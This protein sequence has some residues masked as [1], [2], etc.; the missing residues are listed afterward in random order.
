MS[1]YFLHSL[2]DHC[3]RLQFWTMATVALDSVFDTVTSVNRDQMFG[4]SRWK[5]WKKTEL[6]DFI[7]RKD[8]TGKKWKVAKLQCDQM[9]KLFF[10]YLVIWKIENLP[11][12]INISHGRFLM[13]PNYKLTIKCC[14]SLLQFYQIGEISPNL[15]T[16]SQ[17]SSMTSEV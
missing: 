4:C 3:Q 10:Q 9:D 6:T 12:A 13:F 2:W 8:K 5:C 17:P 7:N 1:S 16:H 11:I 15:V 14:P